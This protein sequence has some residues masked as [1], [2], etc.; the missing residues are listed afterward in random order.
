M[1]RSHGVEKESQEEEPDRMKPMRKKKSG[2]EE[3]TRRRDVAQPLRDASRALGERL[4]LPETRIPLD[5]VSEDASR[6]CKEDNGHRREG[7]SA[8]P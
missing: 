2:P 3:E 5:Y 6:D 7:E 1:S 4:R 8:D